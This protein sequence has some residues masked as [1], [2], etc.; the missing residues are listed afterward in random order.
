MNRPAWI[1]SQNEWPVWNTN[2]AS[3][4]VGCQSGV[5][6]RFNLREV[7]SGL[8]VTHCIAHRLAPG[9]GNAADKIKYLVKFQYVLSSTYKYIA[10]S[11]RNMAIMEGIQ[12]VLK[13]SQTSLQQHVFHTR[14]LS[15][16]GSAQ[17]VVDNF[18]PL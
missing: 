3:V 12:S 15:F 17:A 18:R 2:G 16:E 5:V 11:P 14:W 4:M 8:L 10:Y 13:A 9:T 1:C 6:A 7:T